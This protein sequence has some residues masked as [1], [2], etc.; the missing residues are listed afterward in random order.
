MTRRSR[1]S[2]TKVLRQGRVQVLYMPTQIY[3][4]RAAPPTMDLLR[5][6]LHRPDNCSSMR[7]GAHITWKLLRPP[8]MHRGLGLY[9]ASARS[10]SA[11][12][13]ASCGEWAVCIRI[14]PGVFGHEIPP[15]RGQRLITIHHGYTVLTETGLA[16]KAH[17]RVT[18][19][20][21]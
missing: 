17:V 6:E 9:R 13:I 18:H 11:F 16:S 19:A 21:A 12:A 14:H 1:R 20:K 8:G 2:Q 4:R 5:T 10:C 7:D 15:P 3:S